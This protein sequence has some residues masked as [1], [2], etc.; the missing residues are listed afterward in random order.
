M[1]DLLGHASAADAYEELYQRAPCGYLT[2]SAD[3]L[4]TRANDTFLSWTGY[5]RDAVVGRPF[6]T[7][8]SRSAQIFHDTHYQPLLAMRGWVRELAF[9]LIR[10]DGTVMPALLNATADR[11]DGGQLGTIRLAMLEV[12][13][14]R[15]YERALLE[16][17]RAAEEATARQHQLLLSIAHEIKTPV[18]V[19]LLEGDRLARSRLDDDQLDLL[20]RFNRSAERLSR[21]ANALGDHARLSYGSVSWNLHRLDLSAL[22]RE[23]TERF[24][25]SARH[26]GLGFSASVDPDVPEQLAGDSYNIGKII[27]N[28]V[29]NAVQHTS[30]GRIDVALQLRRRTVDTVTVE[31]RVKDTGDGIEAARLPTIFEEQQGQGR[32]IYLGAGLG[33][34]VAR[35]LARLGG[36]DITVESELGVGSTFTCELRLAIP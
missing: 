21:L 23:A 13:D 18:A 34:S 20:Q 12:T 6:T 9:D 27:D 5:A 22:V 28:L 3:G 16:A 25:I 2:T 15:V 19:L 26:K 8:L 35:Q 7:L 1:T 29:T 36:G 14:R 32:E 24:A 31:L 11:E 33:L 30:Q 10:A 4:V 17:R